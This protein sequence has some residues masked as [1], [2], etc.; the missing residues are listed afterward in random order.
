METAGVVALFVVNSLHHV[1]LHAFKSEVHK[2]SNVLLKVGRLYFLP[3]CLFEVWLARGLIFLGLCRRNS[4]GVYVNG[5]GE[6][7]NP[8]ISVFLSLGS[9]NKLPDFRF[10][11]ERESP[12]RLSHQSLWTKYRFAVAGRLRIHWDEVRETQKIRFLLLLVHHLVYGFRR[13]GLLG[14]H[15]KPAIFEIQSEESPLVQVD[16]SSRGNTIFRPFQQVA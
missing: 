12:L 14:Q 7:A 2:A 11:H 5:S 16:S 8:N 4:W 10:E 13:R 15:H 6:F 3:N 9:Q 1:T